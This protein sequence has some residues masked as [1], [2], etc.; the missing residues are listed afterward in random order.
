MRHSILFKTCLIFFL[1]YKNY[2]TS[3]SYINW[4][5]YSLSINQE[6]VFIQS[7]EFHPWRLPS[8]GQWIDILQKFSAAGLNTVS[9]Y[10]HRG[11]VNPIEGRTDWSGFRALQPIFDAARQ[12]GLWVIAETTAGGIPGW[13]TNLNVSLRTNATEFNKSWRQYWIELTELIEPNQFGKVNG[14]VIAVQVENEYLNDEHSTEGQPSGKDGYMRDLEQSLKDNGIYV[15]LTFNDANMYENFV[16]G[17]GSVDIYGFDSYPQSFDC[18]HPKIWKP[19][20]TNYAKYQSSLKLNSPLFMPEFQ[21]GA[22]DPWG[23]HAAGYDKCQQLTG[24]DFQS[25]FNLNNLAANAKMINYYMAFGGTSWGYI[26]FPGVYTSYDYGA[27]ISEDRTLNEKFTELKRQSLFLRSSKD[28][29]KTDIIGDSSTRKY[30]MGINESGFVTELRNKDN[31]AGYYILRAQDSTS[32]ESTTC[33][34][35]VLTSLGSIKLPT[36]TLPPRR[37]KLLVTDYSTT[38][39]SSPDRT[40]SI[41]LTYTTSNVLL[42]AHIGG[43]EV[44]YLFS[45]DQTKNK[46]GLAAKEEISVFHKI[47]GLE[48][49]LSVT[50][51]SGEDSKVKVENKI[52]DGYLRVHWSVNQIEEVVAIQTE[53]GAILLTSEETAGKVWN[54]ILDSNPSSGDVNRN[55]ILVWGPYLVRNASLISINEKFNL[56]LFGDL[57]ENKRTIISIY[58]GGMKIFKVYWNQRI[59]QNVIID[60]LGFLRFEFNPQNFVE[61]S[62]KI[63]NVDLQK[64][65][66]QIDL[67]KFEWKYRDS[68]PEIKNDFND[69]DWIHADHVESHSPYE[70][71]FGKYYLYA[72]DYGFCNGAA[73]WRGHFNDCSPDLS[74]TRF[75]D[76]SQHPPG[77]TLAISGGD[78]FAASVWINEIFINSTVAESSSTTERVSMTEQSYTFPSGSINKCGHNVITIVQ[79]SMGMDEV[80]GGFSDTVKHPRGILGYRFNGAAVDRSDEILWKVQ[81]QLGG[82]HWL[83]DP[84]RG[85]L[86]ENGFF[87]IRSGWHLPDYPLRNSTKWIQSSPIKDGINKAGIGFYHTII[88][89]NLPEGY[90]IILSFNFDEIIIDKSREFNNRYR[91]EFWVNGWNMG[92]YISDLGPQIRFPVH[93]GIL[94]FQGSNDFGLTVWSLDG[95]GAKIK[96]LS[97]RLDKVLEGGIGSV[98][99]LNH[100][101]FN[102]SKRIHSSKKNNGF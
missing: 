102:L 99:K 13:V 41:Q 49:N 95:N 91:V 1:Y 70:K 57:E 43:H 6:R 71:L 34:L 27:P 46:P 88:N 92:R 40:S 20:I 8:D 7:G 54:P 22:F 85:I 97:L 30:C 47:S 25:V 82:F 59:I 56:F 21:A 87:A 86:N 52:Q 51:W 60:R 69:D 58:I 53:K 24:S 90:D 36:I 35:Q 23:P 62:T 94:N 37:S 12:T 44:L 29:Y 68:L 26:S 79:D 84:D 5:R 55:S 19:V 16:H 28:F 15:P 67:G 63:H 45:D 93:E 65:G 42:S 64:V 89:L 31:G 74:Q 100:F 14:T 48:S 76:Q 72:C 75:P 101:N 39:L 96:K 98:K 50:S 18:S 33:T 38:S 10:V 78:S 80:E 4:D 73:I 32:L 81:G 17:L 11:L 9:I 61:K 77:I 66:D 83:P 3:H 2:L